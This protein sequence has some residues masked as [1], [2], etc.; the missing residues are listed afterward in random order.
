MVVPT[1]LSRDGWRLLGD[2]YAPMTPL[3]PL[4]LKLAG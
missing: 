1:K 4:R 2:H 3:D